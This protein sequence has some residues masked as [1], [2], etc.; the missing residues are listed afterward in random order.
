[1]SGICWAYAATFTC[2]W[3]CDLENVFLLT[4][5]RLTTCSLGTLTKYSRRSLI[6]N[7]HRL[8]DR[9]IY[10]RASLIRLVSKLIISSESHSS[11]LILLVKYT[12]LEGVYPLSNGMV[13]HFYQ[14]QESSTTKTVH[15]VINKGLKTYV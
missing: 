11:R 12:E 4:F 1:M 14:Q 2:S 7:A 8:L 6:G 15:K 9:H 13:L 10:S 3:V 5:W